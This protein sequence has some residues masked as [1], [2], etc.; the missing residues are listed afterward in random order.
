MLPEFVEGD[1]FR[2]I[3][4]LDE[5]YSFDFGQNGQTNQSDQSDQSDQSGQSDQMKLSQDEILLLNLIKEYPDMTN[6]LLAEKLGWSAGRVKY[7]IQKLK[8]FKKI[9]RNGTSR[10]GRWEVL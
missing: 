10:N 9:K 4:P 3:V 1:V 8:Q 2:I 7:Y 6:M 5:K